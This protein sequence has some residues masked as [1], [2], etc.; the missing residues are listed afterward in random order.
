MNWNR[1]AWLYDKWRDSVPSCPVIPANQ[2]R[3]S[4][5][6]NPP[7]DGGLL[8]FCVYE[9]APWIPLEHDDEYGQKG[10]Q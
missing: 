7:H 9:P 8:E 4:L 2:R 5:C 10:S 3:E 1:Y 6:P